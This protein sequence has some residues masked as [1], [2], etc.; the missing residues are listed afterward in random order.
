[1]GNTELIK[2]MLKWSCIFVFALTSV[3]YAQTTT[4]I[5]TRTI[6]LGFE[7]L[8]L[9]NA[10]LALERASGFQLTFPN[11]PVEAA[12]PVTL[13]EA[14]RT[15]EATLRL[16]LDGSGLD[17]Q[18]VGNNIVLSMARETPP[19]AVAPTPVPVSAQPVEIRGRVTMSGSRET[20]P[21]VSIREQG[22]TNFSVSDIDGFFRITVASTSS[23]LQFNFIGMEAIEERVGNRREINVSMRETA[24][25]L[26]E[27]VITGMF[28][29]RA[30]GFAGSAITINNEQILQLTAGNAL[31]ALEMLDPGFQ[32]MT[33]NLIGSNPSGIPDFQMR[34]SAVFGDHEFEDVAVLRGDLTTRP[35]MPLFVLDGVI[36]VS[37]T[38]IMDLDPNQIETITVLKDAAATAIYGSEA[39]NGVVI[40]E[41]R[42]PAAGQLTVTYSGSFQLTWPDLSSYNLTNARE[43]LDVELLAGF[44]DEINNRDPTIIR[45][46]FNA[47]ERDVMR[48]VDTDWL[49]I[50]LQTVFTQR[51]NLGFEGGDQTLRYSVHLGANWNPGVIR[52]TYMT[53]QQ[54]RINIIYRRNR[55]QIFNQTSLGNSRGTRESNFGSFWEYAMMNPYLMPMDEQ[56]NIR[57]VLDPES[58]NIGTDF[59][60]ANAVTLNPLYNT[61]FQTRNEF[62]ELNFT[63]S[64]RLEYRPFPG[65]RTELDF[66]LGSSRG[67]TE[68]FHS[69]HHNRF[70]HENIAENRGRY[71]YVTSNRDHYRLSMSA[72][73][74]NLFDRAHLVSLFGRYTMHQNS[75]YNSTLTM[76]GFPNDRLSEIFMGTRFQG[77]TGAE[78][79]TRSMG[80][81]F[82]GNYSYR[83]RYAADVSVRIDASSQFGRNNRF[84]PFWATGL[85]W[86]IH[87]EPFLEGVSFVNEL[88]IRGSV[89]TTGSQGFNAWQALQTYSYSGH[90]THYT[91]SNVIGTSLLALGN[92]NLRW[93]HTFNQN[94]GIDVTLFENFVGFR[95]ELYS[96]LTQNTLLDYTLAPSIGFPT[97]RENMGEISNRG[98]EFSL[99]LMPY[100]NVARRTFLTVNINGSHNRTTIE[101]ISEALRALNEALYSADDADLTRPLPQFVSGASNTAIW[102]VQSLGICR[103]TGEEMFLGRGGDTTMVWDPRD[104]VIIGERRATLQGSITTTFTRGNFS[105]TLGA[106]YTF[107]G[108]IYNQT[109]ADR[110]ENANLRQNVDRRVLQDRWQNP[111]DEA[112]F[113]RI[114]G[115][116]NR[117]PTRATSRFVMINNMFHLSTLNI[118]YRMSAS[119]H[120]GLRKLGMSA[121]S[122]GLFWDDIM[123]FSTVRMEHGTH[124]PFARTIALSINA[125][126]N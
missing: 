74:H 44:R 7:D 42:R 49:R 75:H 24:L 21:G 35:N 64:V 38:T 73:Y 106:R 117:E 125:T 97:I 31:R 37:V 84:A 98:Y 79:L 86:N 93:Q 114:D 116:A 69:A 15:V 83:Q 11:E 27:V 40:V 12:A 126:F 112:K 54:G 25:E 10:L 48:G 62:S 51:H 16:L 102:G 111:G 77:V 55:I 101:R 95:F 91:S 109:L 52:G 28:E 6:T 19:V 3:A 32:I 110:V 122:F 100:R 53:G 63:Q 23:V 70:A 88:V 76:T 87:N 99:R 80:F 108:E 85:R 22:T 34:G 78:S 115:S 118:N 33:S 36:G 104:R 5:R 103:W 4:D 72:S 2:N 46:Y 60:G 43:K 9:E 30:E 66:T 68:I 94:I 123:R 17:F 1:M 20:M 105:V 45:N 90:M 120:P 13:A 65:L 67:A 41:T 18:V 29:R 124:F 56:G 61:V 59:Q 26:G 96:R 119:E 89:G 8:P 121:V 47:L 71:S 57:R 58:L 14:E 107:G 82:S 113:R 39:A 81:V 92:P 50:P